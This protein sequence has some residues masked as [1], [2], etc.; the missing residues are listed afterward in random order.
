MFNIRCFTDSFSQSR[1]FQKKENK[2]SCTAKNTPTRNISPS[3]N[4]ELNAVSTVLYKVTSQQLREI[5]CLPRSCF[6]D[7]PIFAAVSCCFVTKI[8]VNPCKYN[9]QN[10]LCCIQINSVVYVK[11][12]LPILIKGQEQSRRAKAA[13]PCQDSTEAVHLH[14]Q[15]HLKKPFSFF[16]LKEVVQA[17]QFSVTL[18]TSSLKCLPD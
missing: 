13:H 1:V 5:F 14:S 9:C 2:E 15:F 3:Y 4:S 17:Q 10:I 7:F 11:Y 16:L 18:A 6:R 12:I 8:Q